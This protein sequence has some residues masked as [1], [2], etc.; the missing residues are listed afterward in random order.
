MS[1]VV[2]GEM[3]YGA[4]KS[5]RVADN[6]R[7]ID[8][9]IASNVVLPCDRQTAR[10]YA[11]IKDQLRAQGTTI[12]ENDIWIAASA[13]QYGLTLVTRDAHFNSVSTLAIARW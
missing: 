4:L 7:R 2:T 11:D 10:L 13:V 8:A 5:A 3:F 9:F 6:M 12:P 1:S